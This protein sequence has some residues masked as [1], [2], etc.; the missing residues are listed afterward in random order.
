MIW[1]TPPETGDHH[2]AELVGQHVEVGLV[3]LGPA[4]LDIVVELEQERRRHHRQGHDHGER[5]RDVAEHHA[6][7]ESAGKQDESE[8]SALRYDDGQAP[9]GAIVQTLPA[10]QAIEH[11]RFDGQQRSRHAQDQQRLRHQEF[12]VERHADGGEEQPEKQPLKRRYVGLEFMAVFRIRKQRAGDERTERRRQA[13]HMHGEGHSHHGQEG[14]CGHRFRQPGRCDQRKEP[15]Q[16]ELADHDDHRDGAESLGRR[17]EIHGALDRRIEREQ[18]HEGDQGDCGEILEQEARKGD[19]AVPGGQLALLVEHLDGEGG[20]RQRERQ[21][22]KQTCLE[23]IAECHPDRAQ[24]DRGQEYLRA[25]ESE[26]RRAE[27]P[28]PDRL[29]F[30]A[31]DEQQQHDAELGDMEHG[32]DLIERVD[33]AEAPGSDQNASK[34]IAKDGTDTQPFRQRRPEYRGTQEQGDLIQQVVG[35]SGSDFQVLPRMSLRHYCVASLS[36]SKHVSTQRKK[37]PQSAN[38]GPKTTA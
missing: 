12:Q 35:H 29:E 37:H 20:R 32:L 10:A 1:P 30:Q 16:Q 31:D 26:H 22:D 3:V 13:D 18:G 6:G 8:L 7:G 21:P 34:Q 38:P 2:M 14:R 17:P 19:A 4:V 23:R 25:A 24:D 27:R 33:E 15:V 28:Q 5:L 9:R 11:N 36:A